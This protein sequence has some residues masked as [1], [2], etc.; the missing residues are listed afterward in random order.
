MFTTPAD[1]LLPRSVDVLTVGRPATRV[2]A[3]VKAAAASLSK[4]GASSVG[5]LTCES[6]EIHNSWSADARADARLVEIV[7]SISIGPARRA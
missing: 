4:A 2:R 7:P 3:E 6:D 5:F 1:Q